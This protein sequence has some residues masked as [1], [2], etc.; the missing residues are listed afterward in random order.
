MFTTAEVADLIG[1]G[2]SDAWVRER[3]AAGDIPAF[4]I[5]RSWRIDQDEFATWRDR[6]RFAPTPVAAFEPPP[7]NNS[8]RGSVTDLLHRRAREDSDESTGDQAATDARTS[9]GEL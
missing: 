6:Q 3:C 4:K 8:H 2:T 5:G 7:A 1:G 9:Q